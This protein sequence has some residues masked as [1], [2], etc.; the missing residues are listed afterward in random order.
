M[1][2]KESLHSLVARFERHQSAVGR[3][4]GTRDRYRYTFLLFERFCD[5]TEIPFESEALSSA[6]MDRFAIWLRETPIREQKGTTK[7]EASGIHA[8]LRDMR[9]FTRWLRSNE[10]LAKDVAFP[11]PK[12]PKRLFRILTEEELRRM[13]AS[14]YLTGD[15]PLAIRNR[16][17][18]AFMLDTGLRREEVASLTLKDLSLER[19]V[20]TVI[21]KGDKERRVFFSSRVRSYLRE[22][23]AIRGVDDEP[24]FHLGAGGIRS[25][26]RRIKE[27]TGLEQFHPHLLR[28]QF[29]TTMLRETR[30]MEYVRLLLGHEDYN[31]TKRYLSLTD[32]DLQE[33]HD[34]GSPFNKLIP[35][36]TTEDQRPARIHHRYSRR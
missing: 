10:L 13:W 15:S 18:V 30:N 9:A 34:E 17:L 26:F 24:L 32:E 8:H 3:A 2:T 33:A 14:K 11:L 29:A 19:R 28:H 16:A 36:D 21:G 4:E 31:T 6:V 20:A 23:L 27:E 22:F 7:R 25:T 12:I 1:D 5:A 35:D